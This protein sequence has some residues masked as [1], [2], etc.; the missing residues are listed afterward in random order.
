[1]SKKITQFRYYGDG[2][3]R[4][5]PS[6][7]TLATYEDGSVFSDVFPISQLGIQSL[8][9]TKF[10]LNGNINP[11]IIGASGIYDLDIKDGS[12]VTDLSFSPKSLQRVSETN[13]NGYLLVDIIYGEEGE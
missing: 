7:G 9:G 3:E 5:Q 11:L 1:M 12:R 2:D 8:P 10:Y 4:N 13:T 6:E